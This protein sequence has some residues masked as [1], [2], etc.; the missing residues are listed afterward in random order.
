V[1]YNPNDFKSNKDFAE[2]YPFI[3]N[4][5]AGWHLWQNRHKN[6]IA[7][8]GAI[9]KIN[10][11]LYFHVPAFVEWARKQSANAA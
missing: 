1:T 5:R 10:K 7:E 6:G 2:E 9:L 4:Q 11:K 3:P 8:A